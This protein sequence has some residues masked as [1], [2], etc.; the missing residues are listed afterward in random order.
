MEGSYNITPDL[1]STPS[2]RPTSGPPPPVS[3]AAVTIILL[4][5]VTGVLGNILV[6]LAVT[7]FKNL[8]SVANYFVV[9][10]AMADLLVCTAIMPFALYLEI[11][12]GKWY[13]HQALCRVWTALDV[14]LSTSSIFHLCAI[15]VDRFSAITA[16]IKYVAKRTRNMAFSRIA[17]VWLLSS[18]VSGPA[19]FL[20]LVDE[21]MSCIVS[22]NATVY[23]V[24]SSV[25]SFYIPCLV[26]LVVYFKIYDAAKRR[27]RRAIG[28]A[29]VRTVSKTP[30]V[31]PNKFSPDGSHG[32]EAGPSSANGKAAPPVNPLARRPGLRLEGVDSVADMLSTRAK[33]QSRISLVHERR[34]ARTIGIVVGAFIV[35]WLPFFTLHS[36][37]NPLCSS[38]LM[39]CEVVPTLYRVFTWVGWCN[40]TL[41][42]I[43]YTVFNDEFRQA[44]HKILRCRRS[45]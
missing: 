34:A 2:I 14:M 35:C 17:L 4:V 9:S 41:N 22:V 28:P 42:P 43:I 21:N 37:F 44:F 5:I 19:L 13:L 7:Q 20:T 6:C 25:F 15:S 16:P 1:N 8:R 36:I 30:Q 27:A 3:V 23:A 29:P 45:R 31:T 33:A 12:G 18:F 11:T 10:L 40:S 38:S 24:C 26:I 39:P 32:V